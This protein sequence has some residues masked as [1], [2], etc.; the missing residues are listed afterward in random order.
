MEHASIAGGLESDQVHV[1]ICLEQTLKGARGSTEQ[2]NEYDPT[3]TLT[4]PLPAMMPVGT[5]GSSMTF[6]F[7]VPLVQIILF[8][9]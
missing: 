8:A 2:R 5:N 1:R 3:A 7:A 4:I 9:K 6:L